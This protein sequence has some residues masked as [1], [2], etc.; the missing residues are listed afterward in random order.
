[1]PK[2][3]E[4]K[5]DAEYPDEPDAKY[6]IMNA[7]GVMHGN[8]ITEKGKDMEAKHRHAARAM[9]TELLKRRTKKR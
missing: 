3:L 5:L 9:G 7:M 4:E 2:F 8:K 6:K 1:M